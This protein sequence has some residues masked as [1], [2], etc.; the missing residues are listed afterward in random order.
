MFYF[1][2]ILWVFGVGL[3]GF[4]LIG[5]SGVEAQK[6]IR[7][8]IV[9]PTFGH[10]P[11]FV[12]REKGFYKK[13]G[14]DAEV[15]VMNRDDL[16]LQSVVSD[17]IQ[18]GNISPNLV[19]LARDKGLTGFKT[20][21]GSF[22]GTTYSIIGQ[23]KFK[24]LEQLKGARIAVSSLVAGSTQVLKYA[25][26]QKGLLY[27]RDYTLLR[28][29]GTTLRWSALQTQQVDAASLAEPVSII[30][31]E[32]GFTNLGDVYKLVPH[33]Q[34]S[35]VWIKEEFGQKNRDVTLRFAR[36]FLT[37][38]K[39]LHDN[40]DEAVELLPK[41]TTLKKEYVRKSWETYT[42]ASIWPRDGKVNPNGLQ[43]VIDLMGEEGTIK[44]PYPKPEDVIDHSYLQESTGR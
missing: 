36:A 18:F 26:K 24:S 15:I 4:V 39:W 43:L 38:L 9:S 32:T 20:I 1:R 17:S 7:I 37:A 10:A 42:Q 3:G 5:A 2:T 33:Y 35:S 30:A 22:N 8:G 16:I 12:A 40:R 11:F 34:L 27:P 6:Q 29:G 21:A 41:T 23:G 13:E 44:K 19:F 14:L 25:L 28:V 31:M